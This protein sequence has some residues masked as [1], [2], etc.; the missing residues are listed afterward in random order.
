MLETQEVK[1]LKIEEFEI[2]NLLVIVICNLEI[3]FMRILF[4]GGGTMGSVIPLLAVAEEL[5][6]RDPGNDFYWLGTRRGPEKE[7]VRNYNIEFK[8]IC[9]GKL[10]RY[11]SWLNFLDIFKVIIGLVQSIILLLIWRPQIIIS[12]G[13]FTAVPV[14]WAGWLLGIPSL[15]H[16]QDVRVG[17]ANKLCAWCAK[18]ITVCFGE[19]LKYY[20]QNKT[21][22]V[23]NPVREALKHLNTESTEKIKA[24]NHLNTK[25]FKHGLLNKFDLSEEL[26]VVLIVGGGTGSTA[27]NN[28][29]FDSIKKLTEFCQVVHI[30]GGRI[31]N[32]ELRIKGIE[33]YYQFDFII[34]MTEILKLA[35]LIV[36]RA[37]M[38]TL[39][40]IAYLKKPAI[41]IPIVDSHQEDNAI[42]FAEREAIVMLDQKKLEAESF[43]QLVKDILGN[44][45]KM[46]TLGKKVNQVIGWGAEEKIADMIL[47]IV[48]NK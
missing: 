5:K 4:T 26:P 16:Q 29:V 39:T 18:H 23:G 2:R 33:N 38:G 12:A 43:V 42:Y 10:R 3:I 31:K 45:K 14:V 17:L 48:N 24:L 20:N 28:L 35:D 15:I 7:V 6:N 21:S 19:S 44:K 8:A 27:I 13:G 25:L 30:T 34:D 37:G 9:A 46:Q 22:V 11:F 1:I 32:N 47:K 40:E 41:I 36:S